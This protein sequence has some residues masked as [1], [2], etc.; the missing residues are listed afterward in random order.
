M[1]LKKYFY[2]IAVVVIVGFLSGLWLVV[3]SKADDPDPK[4]GNQVFLPFVTTDG[5][6]TNTEITVKQIHVAQSGAGGRI[7]AFTF[8]IP[9]AAEAMAAQFDVGSTDVDVNSGQDIVTIISIAVNRDGAVIYY[10]QWEDTL[11][12]DL[13]VPNQTTTLVWGDGD[14][15]NNDTGLASGV[16][17]Q[18]IP[19][20]DVLTAGT[21]ITLRNTVPSTPAGRGTPPAS[22]FLGGGYVNFSRRSDCRQHFFL[23]GSYA[24]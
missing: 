23:D 22:F 17:P 13:T 19:A 5:G 6:A 7:D 14:P 10:D 4:P 16:Q 18:G 11:E 9:Y 1:T 21:V 3:Q 2:W 8:Y 24:P 20:N 15:T 12:A